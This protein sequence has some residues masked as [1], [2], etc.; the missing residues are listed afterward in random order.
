MHYLRI[1]FDTD[2]LFVVT[3]KFDWLLTF[4]TYSIY[5]HDD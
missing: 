4:L 2:G 3:D 5:A 1:D